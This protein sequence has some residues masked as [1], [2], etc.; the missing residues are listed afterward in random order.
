[1]TP[2]REVKNYEELSENEI[3]EKVKEEVT[4]IQENLSEKKIT[5]DEA[6]ADLK[7]INERIQSSKLEQKDKKEI[8][9]AF[10]QL[11]KLEKNIDEKHLKDEVDKIINLLEMLVK[12]DLAS[13]EHDVQKKHQAPER[14]IEVKKWI[15]NA[16][17]NLENTVSTAENDENPIAK[18]VGKRMKYL[19]S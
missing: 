8:W 18:T 1:M 2:N 16:S 17:E 12:K 19:M 14:P 9:K 7:K 5:V 3:F 13:L 11:T 10:E 4:P 6:K 15:K